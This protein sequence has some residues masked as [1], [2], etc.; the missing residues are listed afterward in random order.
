VVIETAGTSLEVQQGYAVWVPEKPQT[1][2]LVTAT[3]RQVIP[4]RP[5]FE[6][7]IIGDTATS[8]YIVSQYNNAGGSS[9]GVALV[10][11]TSGIA[12]LLVTFFD[13]NGLRLSSRLL[14][15]TAGEHRAFPLEQ[16]FPETTG[17]RGFFEITRVYSGA[18][19]SN[20]S[21]K[22]FAMLPLEFNPTGPFTALPVL[23]L[24]KMKGQ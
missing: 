4:G 20:A 6:A 1:A 15:M 3:F 13:I 5:D 2:I 19:S 17:K 7:A 16:Y 24:E 21:S 22:H 8:T 11:P 10:N 12:D 23:S 9:T 14:S 18:G